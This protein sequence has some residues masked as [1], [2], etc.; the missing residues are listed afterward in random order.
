MITTSMSNT[1]ASLQL[2]NQAR[3]LR[4]AR[5]LN[6]C[7]PARTLPRRADRCAVHLCGANEEVREDPLP[8]PL[9]QAGEGVTRSPQRNPPRLLAREPPHELPLPRAGEGRGE[10][11]RDMP[12]PN[13]S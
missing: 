5:E 1:T 2:S 10:G 3:P 8:L 7:G 11:L 6:A 12:N 9:P 4:R 13:S